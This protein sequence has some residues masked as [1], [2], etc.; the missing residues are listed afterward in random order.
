VLHLGEPETGSLELD[1]VWSRGADKRMAL[2][3]RR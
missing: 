1:V 3:E 2:D